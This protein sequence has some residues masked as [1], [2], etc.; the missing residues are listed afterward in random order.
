MNLGVEPPGVQGWG[1]QPFSFFICSAAVR[2]FGVK[3][4]ETFSE[5]AGEDGCATRKEN[6]WG[7]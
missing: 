5:L 4:S 7:G 6:G 2:L 1:W 3:R